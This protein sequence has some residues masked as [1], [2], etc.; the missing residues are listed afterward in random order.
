MSHSS[1]IQRPL[2]HH[3]SAPAR[4]RITAPQPVDVRSVI[5]KNVSVY[6]GKQNNVCRANES[7]RMCAV[8]D[9]EGV[10]LN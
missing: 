4:D 3:H 9:P 5:F 6:A 10:N 7:K 8:N 2:H 1:N